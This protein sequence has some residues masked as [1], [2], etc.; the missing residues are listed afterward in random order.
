MAGNTTSPLHYDD[1]ENLLCQIRGTKEITLFPP[2]DLHN[3]YYR[4]RYKGL[5]DYEYPGKFHRSKKVDNKTKII[6]G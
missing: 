2:S 1:Y 5:L 4:G 6:F 3:L